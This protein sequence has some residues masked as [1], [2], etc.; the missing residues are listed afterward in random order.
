MSDQTEFKRLH[1][2]KG[3]FTQAEDWEEGQAY[4]IEKRKLLQRGLHRP[5]II[6]GLEVKQHPAGGLNVQVMPGVAL[7]GE[8]NLI[9]LAA[10]L[11]VA[12][13]LPDPLPPLVY[14][15]IEFHETETDYIVNA[16]DSDYSGY[17]R[18]AEQ[19]VVTIEIS[20]PDSQEKLELARIALGPGVTEIAEPANPDNPL[21][22]EIDRRHV[23]RVGSVDHDRDKKLGAL[24]ERL[25][26]LHAYHQERLEHLHAYH[27][28]KQQRHNRGLFHAG[29]MRSMLDEF[30]V[31]PAGGLTVQVKSGVALDGD[32][33]EVYLDSSV[34]ITLESP[35]VTTRIYVAVRYQDDFADYVRNQDRPFAGTYRTAEVGTLSTMPDNHTWIELARL[36]LEAGATE[37]RLPVD[38]GHPQPN[39]IDR[40][41]VEWAAALAVVSPRLPTALRERIAQLMRDKR[42]DFAALAARFPVP[43]ATDVRQA[44][45]NLETLARNDSLKQ[46]NLREVLNMLE[47]LEQDVGQEIGDRFPPVVGKTEYQDYVAA[48]TALREALYAGESIDVILTCQATVT[49]AARELAE[50]VFRAPAADAGPDQ[51]VTSTDDDAIVTLDASGS[52]AAGDQTIVGYRWE[53]EQ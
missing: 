4:H 32:G 33:H 18:V 40:R 22:N 44:A 6:Q 52:R 25:E 51:T 11:P 10:A 46:E 47:V 41:S 42:R 8:G 20:E 53:K 26:L 16:M 37:V 29:I 21:T 23:H 5:G 9:V 34:S 30:S 1:F 28:E 35:A 45:L 19:A 50:V 17:S 48:V 3:F 15:A 27:L 49:M 36:D 2:F 31:V 14:V 12:V 38:P 39:E 13:T 7:D 24:Q 43:S